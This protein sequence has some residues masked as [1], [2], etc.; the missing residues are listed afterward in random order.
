MIFDGVTSCV[1]QVRVPLLDS[2]L[3]RER[4]GAGPPNIFNPTDSISTTQR[5]VTQ[6]IPT[7]GRTWAQANL[8]YQACHW[9]L[10]LDDPQTTFHQLS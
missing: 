9:Q 1:P 4:T 5:L 10:L 6:V 8:G 3:G 7:E 2:N